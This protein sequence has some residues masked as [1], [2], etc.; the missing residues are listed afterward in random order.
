LKFESDILPTMLFYQIA[1][2]ALWV[3]KGAASG[4]QLFHDTFQLNKL[5]DMVS[6]AD[7]KLKD[8][9]L[10]DSIADFTEWIGGNA[11]PQAFG[12]QPRQQQCVDAGY[13]MATAHNYIKHH[14]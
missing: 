14:R 1:P 6:L 8:I 13:C 5:P 10:P 4:S 9:V 12:L 7:A 2:L 11:E 3:S